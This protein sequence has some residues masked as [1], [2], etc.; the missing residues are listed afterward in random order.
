MIRL[1]PRTPIALTALGVAP[2]VI[3][4]IGAYTDTV[5]TLFPYRSVESVIHYGIIILSFMTGILWGFASKDD[6]KSSYAYITSVLPALYVFFFVVGTDAD[7]LEA[8]MF[9]FAIILSIDLS[10]QQAKLAPNWWMSL[11]I[12]ATLVVL[13]SLYLTRISV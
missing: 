3:G 1:P 6:G 8:L 2:F 4:S 12:P 10:F 13:A 5:L 7:R 9:G 11:R